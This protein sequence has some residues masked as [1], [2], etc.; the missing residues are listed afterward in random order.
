M[1]K[2]LVLILVGQSI[3][4]HYGNQLQ[5]KEELVFKAIAVEIAVCYMFHTGRN[6][7]LRL[8]MYI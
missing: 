2:Q 8:T 7:Q 4:T 3:L 5:A 6:Q 1:Q